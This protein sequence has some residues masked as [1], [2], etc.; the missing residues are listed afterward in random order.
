MVFGNGCIFNVEIGMYLC[1]EYF[2]LILCGFVNDVRFSD[3]GVS[4]DQI[5]CL[6]LVGNDLMGFCYMLLDVCL[7][8]VV[9]G[10]GIVIE[11]V[12]MCVWWFYVEFGLICIFDIGWGC[13]LCVGVV[14][15]VLGQDVLLVVVQ[16]ISV[17]FNMLQCGFELNVFYKWF[18]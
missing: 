2:N 6:V 11:N 14:G 13:N 10:V 12:Y 17:M 3:C 4:D 18:Y 15:S 1:V 5:V 9:L 16:S 7:W 8:G